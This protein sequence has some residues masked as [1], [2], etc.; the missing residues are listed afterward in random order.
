MARPI[1]SADEHGQLLDAVSYIDPATCSRDEWRNVG[2]GLKQSGFDVSEW[3][4]WSRRDPARFHEGECQAQWNSF[5]GA[6][7]PISSGTIIHMAE[8]RGWTQAHGD[9]AFD[10]DE[11]V[12]VGVDQSWIEPE[13]VVTPDDG[14]EW[15]PDREIS[16]YL[17]ALFDDDDYVGYVTESWERDGRIMPKSGSYGRTAGQ[18]RQ[19]LARYANDPDAM[20]K[21]FGDANPKA[22]AWIRFNPLDG[23]G[24]GNRNVTEFRYALVESDTVPVDKQYGMIRA[25]NLPCVA[26]VSSGGKSVHA[27][28]RID[29]GTDFDLYRKR[30]ERLYAYCQ[31]HGFSPDTQNKNPSRLSR[32]P[33]F[34]RNGNRQRL[35]GTNVGPESWQA[36][37][38]WA[39][40]SEDDLPDMESL[41][42]KLENPDPVATPI[43][44]TEEHGILRQG[45]KMI[46]VGPSKAG[47][48]M[49]LMELAMA[50]ASGTK[51]LG[52]PCRQGKVMYV[53]LEIDKASCVE[54][55]QQISAAM[56][57]GHEWARN[58]SLWNLRGFS[59]PMDKITPRLIHRARGGDYDMVIIDPIYKVM[60]GDENSASDMAKFC[61]EFDRIAH[62]LGTAV[63]Y[64]HHQSKGLQGG[65][66]SIDRASGSGVFAR[67]PDAI[68]DMTPLV[69]PKDDGK[70]LIDNQITAWRISATLR[71]FR[72]PPPMDV[73]FE[74]PLH[75]PDASGSMGSWKMEGEDPLGQQMEQRRERKKRHDEEQHAGR[76]RAIRDAMRQCDD[77]GV[78]PTRGNVLER[79]VDVDGTK[80]SS[81]QLKYWTNPAKSPWSPFS[82]EVPDG[83]PNSRGV[84]VDNKEGSDVG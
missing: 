84:I 18:L 66:R 65:K 62:E 12:A 55:F 14:S 25:M 43:I 54:R 44:G 17:A 31:K 52:Y 36:W 63:V 51:W 67:D 35:L 42:D 79:I 30:V 41:Y 46:V 15:H 72:T 34:V 21:V 48:S 23:R 56:H 11:E 53:N 13:D 20:G 3:V 83:E 64:A 16:D 8:E 77:D 4:E 5:K 49:L 32:M 24:V 1:D 57:M 27:I 68:L 82:F 58:V 78:P 29:A 81:A 60:T 37:E 9:S 40:E 80:V 39:I 22:G 10:W 70:Y 71:E 2:M 6:D 50:V 74:Y 28:V 73:M 75:L 69:I 26:V 7:H 47:K 76:I 61:N 38:D 33:G 59:A 45:H 19:E